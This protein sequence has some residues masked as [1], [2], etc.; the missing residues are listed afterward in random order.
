MRFAQ[1]FE[2]FHRLRLSPRQM[3][4]EQDPVETGGRVGNLGL[5]LVDETL[6]GILLSMAAWQHHDQGRTVFEVGS[7]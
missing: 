5:M 2:G 4:L 1:R 7:G 6:S 3:R